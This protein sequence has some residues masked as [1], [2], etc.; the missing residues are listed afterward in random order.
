MKK[1]IFLL[2]P[3]LLISACKKRTSHNEQV[4]TIYVE[5]GKILK[6]IKYSEL[7]SEVKFL[8]LETKDGCLIGKLDKIEFVDDEI[9]TL[10][11]RKAKAIHHFTADGKFVNKISQIGGGPGDYFQ[12]DDISVNPETHEIAI[13]D[14]TNLLIYDINS[15]YLKRIKMPVYAYKLA[16][17]DHRFALYSR[18]EDALVLLDETG[19][20]TSKFFKT[21]YVKK[22]VLNRPFQRFD[23][24][25]VLYFSHLDYTI[26]S[27]SKNRVSPHIKFVFEEPMFTNKDEKSLERDENNVENFVKLKY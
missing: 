1:I 18:G 19:K 25:Q 4:M 2:L 7:F 5:N 8:P 13:L 23:S 16:W 24:A 3:I 21:N 22:L 26:Y 9:V 10:D 11:A 20:R 6:S 17:Y 15:T 12:P 27:I 14:R